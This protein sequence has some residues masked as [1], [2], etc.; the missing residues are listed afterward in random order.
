MI[1]TFT[2]II[3]S[4]IILSTLDIIF[5]APIF[6]VSPWYFIMAILLSTIYEFLIDGLFALIVNRLPNSAFQK[7]KI[8]FKVSKR[9]QKFLEKLGIRKWKDKIWELGSLGGFSKSKLDDN[10]TYEYVN[11]FLTESY[12]GIFEHILGIIL[13]FTVIFIFPLKFMWIIGIPVA[14]VNLFINILS[15][16][17]LRYNIPKLEVLQKR[18]VRNKAISATT[19][20]K[21]EDVQ[22]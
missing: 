13:G 1:F 11:R 14:I 5:A 9:E 3:V 15:V 6:A 10:P 16:M 17:V 2:T 8:S 18:V 20:T 21:K 4:I 7:G 12:K 22:N 19:E